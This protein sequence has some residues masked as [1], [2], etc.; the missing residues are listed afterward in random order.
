MLARVPAPPPVASPG[1]AE[2]V[3]AELMSVSPPAPE[4]S[5]P[6]QPPP[7]PGE[8]GASRRAPSASMPAPLAPARK[9]GYARGSCPARVP[10]GAHPT[11]PGD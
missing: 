5:Y 8:G 6:R 7:V 3:A 2:E 11:G 4:P 9:W 1:A 10:A